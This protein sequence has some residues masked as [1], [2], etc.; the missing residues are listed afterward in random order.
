MHTRLSPHLGL[1]RHAR[2]VHLVALQL[3]DADGCD[4]HGEAQRVRVLRGQAERE[5]RGGGVDAVKIW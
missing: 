5:W 2:G 1:P 3:A 4:R